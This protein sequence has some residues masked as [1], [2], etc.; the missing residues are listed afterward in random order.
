MA[1]TATPRTRTR[2]RILFAILV[3]GFSAAVLLYWRATAPA[4]NPLGYD[5]ADTKSYLRQMEVYGGT[6]N[7]LAS[8]ARL[9][10]ASLWQGERLAFTIAFLTLV[11]AW[12]FWFFTR[13]PLP[14]EEEE[15]V[16]TPRGP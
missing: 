4:E 6:A 16:R 7:E 8:E 9:W 2:R 15:D 1:P 11:S 14:G 13:P 12:A 3:C 5:P 10:F